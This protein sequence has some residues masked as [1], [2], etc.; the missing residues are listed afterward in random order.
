MP[1]R[2]ATVWR[3]SASVPDDFLE[4][5]AVAVESSIVLKTAT[6]LEP[7]NVREAVAFA[8]AYGPVAEE[9]EALARSIRHT[10]SVRRSQAGTDALQAYNIAKGLARKPEGAV[11]SSHIQEMKRT[12]GRGGHKRVTAPTPASAKN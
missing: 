1:L 11:L 2:A 10:I 8:T 9:A 6:G 3:T 7:D 12:L 5:A 4:A